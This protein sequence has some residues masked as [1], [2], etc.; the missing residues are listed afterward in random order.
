MKNLF[1]LSLLI[2]AGCFKTAEQVK[3]EQKIE[4]LDRQQQDSRS[5]VV[6]VNQSIKEMQRKVDTLSGQIEEVQHQ[7]KQVSAND[8][9][10]LQETVNLIKEQLE[11][12]KEE[13]ESFKEQLAES[14]KEKKNDKV[15]EKK[16]LDDQL[17]DNY[18]LIKKKQYTKARE[19]LD[20]LLQTDIN[21]AQTNK[22]FHQ[23]GEI[24]LKAKQYEKSLVY[25]SK[26]Y[27]KYP[28]SSL[29]PSSL[30]HIGLCLKNLGKSEEAS[31]A[32]SE[33][34][35]KFPNS[36]IVKKAKAEMPKS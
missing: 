25:F 8:F 6:E 1:L 35:E 36:P 32:F 7:Q 2:L 3:R 34:I 17:K 31:Q 24:E 27:T 30:F 12:L 9:K 33:L 18:A 4:T 10:A 15:A 14:K 11:V 13:Q 29:A 20:Q 23:Y 16:G 21:A 19:I 28:Q 5:L 22:V 26:I